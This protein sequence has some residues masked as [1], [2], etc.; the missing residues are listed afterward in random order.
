MRTLDTIFLFAGGNDLA[1]EEP[2]EWLKHAHI[3]YRESD[4]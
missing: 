3:A 4:D 1:M 2:P